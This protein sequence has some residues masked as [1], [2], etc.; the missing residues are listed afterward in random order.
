M[1]TNQSSAIAT[2]RSLHESGCFVLPNPWDA[3]SAVALQRIGFSALAG[4]SAGLAFSRGLPDSVWALSR[5]VVLAHL[6]ELVSATT[7]P[8]T[9]D[10]QGGYA[11]EPEGVAANV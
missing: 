10:F 7:I 4:T 5:D 1:T 3:G 2:F 8:V 11:H 6:R 9:A